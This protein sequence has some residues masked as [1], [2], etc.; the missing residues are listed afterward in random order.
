MHEAATKGTFFQDTDWRGWRD[1]RALGG[2][3]LNVVR[4]TPGKRRLDVWLEVIQR[5]FMSFLASEYKA[6]VEKLVK[7]DKRLRFEDV[8]GTGRLSDDSRL[9]PVEGGSR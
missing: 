5:N 1:A 2:I 7:K 3:V 8:K 9:Y 4:Q 6:T